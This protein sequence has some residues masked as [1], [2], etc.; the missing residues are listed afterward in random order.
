MIEQG[1]GN[2]YVKLKNSNAMKK[3]YINPSMSISAL[4][5]E[6]IIALSNNEAMGKEG[7]QFVKEAGNSNPSSYNVWDDDWSK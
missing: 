5:V 7:E 4:Q 2:L 6:Q 3:T 1:K